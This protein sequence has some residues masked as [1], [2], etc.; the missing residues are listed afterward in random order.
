MTKELISNSER[1]IDCCT[2]RGPVKMP[3]IR[4]CEEKLKITLRII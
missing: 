3:I 2:A 4:G 1:L